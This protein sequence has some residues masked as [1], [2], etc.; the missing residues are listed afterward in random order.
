MNS[1]FFP[2]GRNITGIYHSEE[3]TM[4]AEERLFGLDKC[5]KILQYKLNY[6]TLLDTSTS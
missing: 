5:N 1:E 3:C 4:T 6:I 2:D